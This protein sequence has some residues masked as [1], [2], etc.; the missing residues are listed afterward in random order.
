MTRI[1]ATIE[2]VSNLAAIGVH[3]QVIRIEV[4]VPEWHEWV[5]EN[6]DL[7]KYSVEPMGYLD[8]QFYGPAGITLRVSALNGAATPPRSR[9]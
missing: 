9:W 8:M 1:Q 3:D 7:T 2:W 5:R 6:S 4:S